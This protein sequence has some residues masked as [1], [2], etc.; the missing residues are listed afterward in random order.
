MNIYTF[1]IL[2]III[3]RLF[4]KSRDKYILISCIAL[5]IIYGLRDGRMFGLD[6]GSYYSTFMSSKFINSFSEL[7]LRN[8]GFNYFTYFI[9]KITNGNYQMYVTIIS[10][11]VSYSFYRTIKKYSVNPLLS[12]MW[13]LGMLYYTL[14]FTIFK[15]SIAMAIL[16]YGLDAIM[17]GKPIKYIAIV[18]TASLFHVPA[19]VLLPAYWLSK[20]NIGKEYLLTIIVVLSITYIFR[21]QILRFMLSFYESG[22]TLTFE[23]KFIGGKVIYMLLV[24]AVAIALRIPKSEDKLYRTML[25]FAGISAV[26][27]TFCYY[28]N[29]FERLADYYYQFSVLLI[30]LIF[31]KLEETG[32]LVRFDSKSV[33][34]VKI[35]V[36]L[37]I[38][39]FAIWRFYD[40]INV[41]A[42]LNFL[43]FKF[44]WQ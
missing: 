26:L 23:P 27:Q 11:F 40:Y 39:I 36:E 29:I 3:A 4:C 13:Y 41:I 32:G 14:N 18:L 15:Q 1:L 38:I 6:A 21:S 42:P 22:E 16:L 34:I 37:I 24:I 43:P 12:F 25:I 7:S 2:F 19:L 28:N 9:Y 35:S 20:V 5:Y 33:K 10:T 8:V 31:E 44:F 17:E 30:P